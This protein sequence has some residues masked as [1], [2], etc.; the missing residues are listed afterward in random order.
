MNHTGIIPIFFF[1]THGNDVSSRPRIVSGTVWTRCDTRM[2]RR[3][4]GTVYHTIPSP[5]EYCPTPRQ[6]RYHRLR[7]ATSLRC[8]RG[9]SQGWAGIFFVK[10]IPV[11]VSEHSRVSNHCIG[12]KMRGPPTV[13]PWTAGSS[14][15][16]YPG[17]KQQVCLH[18]CLCFFARPFRCQQKKELLPAPKRESANQGRVFYTC[19]WPDGKRCSFFRWQDENHQYSEVTIRNPSSADTVN[20]ETANVDPE[21]QIIAWNGTQQGSDA[22]HRLRACRIRAECMPNTRY[23][24]LTVGHCK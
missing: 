18:Q 3:T 4:A 9:R 15:N 17:S 23:S 19:G 8:D 10:P 7:I 6:F 14:A 11:I 12:S 24:S 1:Y 20:Q 2:A 16:L 13:L 21:L 22:W 5:C